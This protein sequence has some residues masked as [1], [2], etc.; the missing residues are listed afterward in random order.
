MDSKDKFEQELERIINEF[1]EYDKKDKENHYV[2]D[3][4]LLKIQEYEFVL[5]LYRKCREEDISSFVE[6]DKPYD[7]IPEPTRTMIVGNE[8][9]S[10][11]SRS[12]TESIIIEE[13]ENCSSCPFCSMNN[14]TEYSCHFPNNDVDYRNIRDFGDNGFPSECPLGE[15]SIFIKKKKALK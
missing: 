8:P 10:D 1:K 15:K 4:L 6:G 12:I 2:N 7:S 3:N 11:N 13:I 5:N 14:T 9:I